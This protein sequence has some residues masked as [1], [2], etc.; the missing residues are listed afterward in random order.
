MPTQHNYHYNE[1]CEIRSI[2][3]D[4]DEKY[5]YLRTKLTLG[6]VGEDKKLAQVRYDL[7]LINSS[8][9]T[10]TSI[11]AYIITQTFRNDGNVCNEWWRGI[12]SKTTYYRIR[13]RAITK[14]L[15]EYHACIRRSHSL[16]H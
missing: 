12:F 8:L 13:V 6:S 4:I 10:L 16:Q 2:F 1:I 3:K 11:E 7:Y 15:K 5:K 9:K 14:F